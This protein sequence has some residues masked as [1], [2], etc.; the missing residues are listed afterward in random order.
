MI[1]EAMYK[2][3]EMICREIRGKKGGR[4]KMWENIKKL[5]KANEVRTEEKLYNDE[6]KE[7]KGQEVKLELTKYWKTIYQARPNEI[8]ETWNEKE[9]IN[10]QELKREEKPKK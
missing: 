2:H 1:K 9:K 8:H 7:I 10:Y 4:N 3:E 5:K 6:G